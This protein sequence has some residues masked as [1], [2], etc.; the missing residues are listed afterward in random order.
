[1]AV[2]KRG[3][4]YWMDVKVRNQ[5]YREPLDTTDS[6]EAK[7]LERERMPQIEARGPVP[8][9][10]SKVYAALDVAAALGAYA[11]ERRVRGQKWRQ[12]STSVNSPACLAEA[13]S[14]IRQLYFPRQG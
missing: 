2:F 13:G 12:P 4:Q 7:K 1:M 5:R 9:G 6:R 8:T 11:R 3:A 14:Q 10:S